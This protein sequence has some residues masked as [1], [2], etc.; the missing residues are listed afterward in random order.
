[1]GEYTIYNIHHTITI[2]RSLKIK[3]MEFSLCHS[4]FLIPLS[5][6]PNNFNL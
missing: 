6:Q 4:N 3:V 5:L 2:H 1:M